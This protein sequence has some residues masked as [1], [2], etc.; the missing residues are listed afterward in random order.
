M[1]P[2]NWD[3][4][5][6]FLCVMRSSSLRQ[7][8]DRMG[9]SHPTVRRHLECLEEQLGLRLFDR[10]SD[11]LHAL[12]AAAELL[13]LAEDIETRFHTLGRRAL[14]ATPALRGPIRVTAPDVVVS[15][16]LMDDLVAFTDR[17]PELDLQVDVSYNVADLGA[18]EADVAIRVVR[19]GKAPSG[20]VTGRKA[21]TIYHAVYGE[22]HQWIG[23]SGGEKDRPWI[24]ETGVYTDLA[25]VGK[26][27]N[28]YAQRSAMA[29][30]MG[31]TMLPCFFAE[32]WGTRRSEP[33]PRFDI[34]VLVHPDLRRNPRLRLFRDEIVAAIR[35]MQPRMAGQVSV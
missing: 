35:R 25:V 13:D 1:E 33:M 2:L 6:T 8:A 17:H 10:R 21:G 12:P 23:W 27:N 19:T 5:R 11:G 16:L 24:E 30:G 3:N 7:A 31:L 32:G 4:L 9:V 29:T 28:P 14:D 18:Q 20:D 22:P 34:W 15:D 26:F